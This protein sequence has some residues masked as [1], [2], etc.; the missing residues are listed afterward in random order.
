MGEVCLNALPLKIAADPGIVVGRVWIRD[1]K[2]DEELHDRPEQG[3]EFQHYSLMKFSYVWALPG[4]KLPSDCVSRGRPLKLGE[5]PARI[6]AYAAKRAAAR[7][8]EAQGFETRT[9]PRSSSRPRFRRRSARS[10]V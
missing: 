7:H 3:E 6:V 5:V 10:P 8:L 1:D 2:F 9:W 4:G